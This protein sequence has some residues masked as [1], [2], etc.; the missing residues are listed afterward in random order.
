M[1]LRNKKTDKIVDFAYL[2]SD[3]IASL[4]LTTYENNIPKMYIYN[5]LA[6]LNKEWED[7]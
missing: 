6:E 5:S 2:Q 1:K 4:V 7:V 3:H